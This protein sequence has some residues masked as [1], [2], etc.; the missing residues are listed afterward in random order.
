MQRSCEERIYPRL[1]LCIS[2]HVLWV[3]VAFI[4]R[5]YCSATLISHR[6]LINAIP[7]RYFLSPYKQ[8]FRVLSVSDRSRLSWCLF[9]L[10]SCFLSCFQLELPIFISRAPSH[11]P[12][13]TLPSSL[14]S[15]VYTIAVTA[16][17]SFII[18]IFI[19]TF[20]LPFLFTVYNDSW[21][22]Y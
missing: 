14:L 6:H 21:F 11:H 17:P 7:A 16:V 19:K 22:H 12:S 9:P 4:V 10:C 8:P 1:G 15:S 18:I 3:C 5:Q 13:V 2:S 20:G